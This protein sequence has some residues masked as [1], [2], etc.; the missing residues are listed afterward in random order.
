MSLQTQLNNMNL[1]FRS[2]KP[3]QSLV[4]VQAQSTQIPTQSTH[5]PAQYTNSPPFPYDYSS[6][7]GPVEFVIK[8]DRV[9]PNPDP[10][11]CYLKR[12][13]ACEQ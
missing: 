12:T 1:L 7:D 4:Q 6:P 5:I 2:A 11:Y 10:T 9:G 8:T 13:H 3:V